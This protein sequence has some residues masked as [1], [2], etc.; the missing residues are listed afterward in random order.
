MNQQRKYRLYL[1]NCCFNRPFDNQKQ[2]KIKLETEAKLFI[3]HEI[4]VGKHELVWSYILEFEN[5]QNPY[6]DRRE[7]IQDWKNLANTLCVENDKVIEFAETL[8]NK[9][10]KVKDA[11]HIACAV[12]SNADFFITT[13]KGLLNKHIPEINIVNPLAIINELN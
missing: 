5:N 9:G 7:A 13:D 10:I 8:F 2:L 1:D 3:Q 12:D 6:K 4:L 11:L